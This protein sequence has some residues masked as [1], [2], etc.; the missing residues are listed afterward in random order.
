MLTLVD[1]DDKIEEALV[2]IGTR[3]LSDDDDVEI[4][5]LRLDCIS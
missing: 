2:G 5:N 1:T 4:L 3:G